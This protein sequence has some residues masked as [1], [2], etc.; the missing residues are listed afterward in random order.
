[1]Q[2]TGLLTS[3]TRPPLD[4]APCTQTPLVNAGGVHTGGGKY[5]QGFFTTQCQLTTQSSGC[6]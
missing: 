6:F 3:D 4:E 2:L 5:F 1:M